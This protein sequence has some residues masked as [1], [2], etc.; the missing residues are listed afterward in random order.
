MFFETASFFMVSR[1][2]IVKNSKA[3]IS[4]NIVSFFSCYKNFS[5]LNSNKNRF[6]E[7]PYPSYS[8]YDVIA[9]AGIK[10]GLAASSDSFGVL[11][12]F[13]KENK[14]WMFGHLC[15]DLKN[16][17]ESCLHSSHPDYIGFSDIDFFVPEIVVLLKDDKLTVIAESENECEK[18]FREL[19]SGK[20]N[21]N[22]T[23]AITFSVRM[24]R[25]EYGK[26]FSSLKHQIQA[27]NIYE[28]TFCRE[29]FAEAEIDPYTLY[30]KMCEILPAPFS[31]LYR[32]DK[33]YLISASPE[34]FLM[35]R[36]NKIV[37]QP[38]KGTYPRSADANIDSELINALKNDVKERSENVMITDLVRNDLSRTAKR[39]SVKV[40]D[41]YG[42]FTFPNV[43]QMVSTVVSEINENIHFTDVIRYAFPMGSMT[44]APKIKAMQL[45]E[46]HEN[47][48]RGLFSGSVGYISPDGDFDFNVII[49]SLLYN[50][51]NRYLS[52]SAG[53]AITSQSDEEK[54]FAETELKAKGVMNVFR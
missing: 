35:K 48:R 16:E 12:K 26:R 6:V 4:E 38:M 9:G 36:G 8:F 11:S 13:C 53:G 46:E 30:N 28:I 50:T 34:R 20:K 29:F 23:N 21:N 54:E 51:S 25:N 40:E 44:G 3:L 1:Q 31:A 17:T 2:Y 7:F 33:K 5:I 43:H 47:V 45:I 27:G 37:S 24:N 18:V 22:V 49:R 42:I 52:L 15:Y 19:T 14:E 39:G 32:N 10:K 41:L